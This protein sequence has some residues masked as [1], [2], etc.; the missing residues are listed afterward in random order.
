MA[1]VL[2]M[3]I[4]IIFMMKRQIGNLGTLKNF[5]ISCKKL[6]QNFFL[7]FPAFICYIVFCEYNEVKMI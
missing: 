1:C 7:E 6:K 2:Y 3:L 5:Y 4:C